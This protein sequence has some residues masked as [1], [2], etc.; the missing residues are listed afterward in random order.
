MEF[1][2][3]YSQIKLQQILHEETVRRI[4]L[5]VKRSGALQN[6]IAK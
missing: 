4:P 5:W 2:V 6:K 1:K 3:N